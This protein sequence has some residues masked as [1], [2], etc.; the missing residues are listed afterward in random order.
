MIGIVSSIEGLA[1]GTLAWFVDIWGVM[2]NG[3]APFAG[4]VAACRA[5]RASGGIVV[6]VS[7][8]PRPAACVIAALDRIG[9]PRDC[10]DAVQSSGDT[11]R[12]LIAALGEGSVYHLG[13]E[14]D[15]ALYEGLPVVR[16]AADE[17]GTIVCTGLVDDDI[18]TGETYRP[19]L[20]AFAARQ[21]PMI[22]ANPDFTVER[23]GRIIPCAG[24]VAAVYE[25]LGGHVS[26]AGKPYL[27]IYDAAFAIVDRL[28]GKSVPHGAILAIGDGVRTDIAGAA[29]AGLR[30]VYIASGVHLGAGPLDEAALARLF[31]DPAIQPLA[32]MTELVW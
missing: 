18:E 5:F 16:P 2:H 11:A 26:Y 8:A 27:P 4:A 22:C 31:P 6:L 13:P 19:L 17:A 21:V 30:S 25:D 9:V 14:R 32:A 20:A 24:A 15:L 23:G 28:A 12:G 1:A 3:V 29:R 7:N 10:Y